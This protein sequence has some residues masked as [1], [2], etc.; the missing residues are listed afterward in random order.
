MKI[1]I[2][3]IRIQSIAN[4]GSLNIGKTIL[5]HNT[6]KAIEYVEPTS[7]PSAEGTIA[8]GA[9]GVTPEI[10]PAQIT[11]GAITPDMGALHAPHIQPAGAAAHSQAFHVPGVHLPS[12]QIPTVQPPSPPISGV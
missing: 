10:S 9:P 4:I 2:R 1:C 8:P 11:P 12:V 7:P 3:N 5:S 6:A